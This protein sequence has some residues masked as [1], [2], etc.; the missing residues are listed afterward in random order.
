MINLVG[1]G[2][3]D[4]KQVTVEAMETLDASDVI[5]VRGGTHHPVPRALLERG[6]NVLYLGA[7]YHIGMRHSEVYEV[8]ADV[9][10]AAS[11]RYRSTT[12]AVPGNVFVFETACTL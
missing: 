4:P 9:V 6:R 12:Y 11:R 8:I 5:F 3:G 1:L 2:P 10:M 7:L